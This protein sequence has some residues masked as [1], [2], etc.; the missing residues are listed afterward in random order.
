MRGLIVGYG[1]IGRRHAGNWS[2]L[3]LG[4]LDVCHRDD[5]ISVL[6]RSRPDV[7]LVC[8]P[9]SLHVA[10][11]CAAVQAGA[12][13]FVEKPIGHTLDGVADLLGAA[14]HAE[15]VVGVA[16]NFRFHPGPARLRELVKEGA[17]GKV[18]SARVECGEYLPDWHPWED[19]RLGYSAR[20]DLGGGAV[21]TI[22]HE[23]DTL[24]WILGAPRR[25]TAF[26]SHASSLEIDTEDVAEIV[27]E[28][29]DRSLASV[30]VDYVRRPRQRSIELVGEDGVL[31]WEYEAN[32]VLRYA[33]A[34]RQWRV[35]EGDPRSDRNQMYRA[36][37]EEF[38]AYV[39][40]DGP[41]RLATGEQGAAIVALAR[42][43]LRSSDSG[44]AIDLAS[45]GEPVT[46]WLSSLGR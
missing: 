2:A 18:L 33:P 26:A 3:D 11:A 45:E 6:L 43:A 46:A 28:F 19:Y 24:C 23:L 9:T 17:I 30:H 32:R 44:T 38:V 10:T 27:L 15:R 4:P 39:R 12:H 22:S 13:V 36:E 1:S 7:V 16:Y 14:R 35:E 20:A 42:A 8:N 25:L 31:R 29:E 41:G 5:D 21:L 37:L 34:T 40:G